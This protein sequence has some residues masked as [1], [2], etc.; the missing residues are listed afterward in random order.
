[1]LE[2]FQETADAT[3][4]DQKEQ[5]GG[6]HFVDKIYRPILATLMIPRQLRNYSTVCGCHAGHENAGRR[7]LHVSFKV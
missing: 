3:T 1:V 5:L 4:E 7:D 2:R 6:S